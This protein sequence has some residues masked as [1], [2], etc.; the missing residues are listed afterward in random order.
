MNPNKHRLTKKDIQNLT[1]FVY[2]ESKDFVAGAFFNLPLSLKRH[3][4]QVGIVAG[5]MAK[6]APDNAIPVGM[7]HDEYANATR[8][9]AL[10]HDIG[11]YLVYNRTR[12][13][14]AA[15]ERFLREQFSEEVLNIAHRVILETVQFYGERYDGQGY[16]DKISGSAIP[17]HAGICAIANKV[18]IMLGNR[19]NSIAEARVSIWENRGKAFSPDAVACFTAASAEIFRLYKLWH[20][21]PPLWNNRDI[22]PLEKPM[23]KP[24]G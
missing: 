16:P 19:Y 13:Y 7:T 1:C 23:D 20:K 11:A 22:N 14:P 3:G 15:G 2:S 12:L 5:Q 4:V 17:L 8:Y 10:Y 21:N 9:G 24:I 6:H 18:D